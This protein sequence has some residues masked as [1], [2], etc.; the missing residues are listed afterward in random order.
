MSHELITPVNAIIGFSQIL[1]R[2]NTLNE[3]EMNY[4]SKIHLSGENLLTLLNSILDFSKIEEGEMD[5]MQVI[6][7][8]QIS[9]F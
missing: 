9:N 8:L 1:K 7:F 2:K 6:N 3:K 5:L 4:I